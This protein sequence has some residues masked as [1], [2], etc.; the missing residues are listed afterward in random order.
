V[1]K[2]SLTPE[3]R[4]QLKPWSDKFVANAMSTKA[5]D[6]EE[7]E[8]CVRAVAGMYAAAGKSAPRVVFVASPFQA[9]FA[10]GFS[11]WVWHERKSGREIL[12]SRPDADDPV[13]VATHLAS[14]LDPTKPATGKKR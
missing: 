7:R 14:A 1:V 10:G 6:D 8:I 13:E 2:Y 3:H 11:A 4:A 9:R 5:M 12:R